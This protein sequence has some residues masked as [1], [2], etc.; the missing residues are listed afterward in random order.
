MGAWSMKKIHVLGLGIDHENLTP[1]ILKRIDAAGVLVGGDRLLA[2]FQDHPGIKIPIRSPLEAVIEKIRGQLKSPKETV[3]LAEGDPGF[4]GIGKR[5]IDAFGK[6]AV[7]IYPN[8]TTLQVAAARVKMPWN[9][10]KTV[11][12]HGRKEMQPLFRELVRNDRIGVYTDPEFNPARVADELLRRGVDVFNMHVFEDLGTESE[13]VA[14]LELKE[15]A[16]TN[17]SPLN[18]IILDRTKNA[19]IP[20]ILGLDDEK[21]LHQKGLITKKEIRA[22]ALSALGIEPTHTVWD[23]GA[24]CGSV[25]V[26]S[27]LLAHEGKVFAVEKDPER[28][29]CIRKN[30]KRTGAFGVDVIEGEMPE[31]LQSL[32]DPHRIFMGGGIGKDCRVLA[33]AAGRLK[34]GGKIV[35]NLVLMGSL[36]RATDYFKGLKWDFYI[37]QVQVSRSKNTAGDQRLAALNPVYILCAA[38]GL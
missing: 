28:V 15:A 19:E 29:R 7:V 6:D 25:A 26:E 11:S 33:E 20:L 10:I 38:P 8:V 23:L 21:Y 30:V 31:C 12:L 16:K 36:T 3:V 34:P 14:R 18:F 17:F 13:K 37:T 2:R 27:S 24:G 32:P 5:L 35:L 1:V 22:V 4:F 9:R